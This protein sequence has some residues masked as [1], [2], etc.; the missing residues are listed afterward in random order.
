MLVTIEPLP[1]SR[2]RRCRWPLRDRWWSLPPY[3]GDSLGWGHWPGDDGLCCPG[4]VSGRLGA[5]AYAPR[6]SAA[7]VWGSIFRLKARDNTTVE[8]GH[9]AD[10]HSAHEWET[11]LVAAL[12][13]GVRQ[14]LPDG[15][16]L[17]EVDVLLSA[18]LLAARARL[19]AE[20][21]QGR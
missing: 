6:L 11:G 12:R 17:T 8:V 7:W 14:Q 15:R 3:A 1:F 20:Q 19:G 10:V 4:A 9:N 13:P 18:E 5:A 16:R 21:C 2:C